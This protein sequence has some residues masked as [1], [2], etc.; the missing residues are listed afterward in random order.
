MDKKGK[1]L[2]LVQYFKN[3]FGG[4]SVDAAFGNL[5]HAGLFYFLQTPEAFKKL[6]LFLGAD[7]GDG[8][9]K[10]SGGLLFSF[11]LMIGDGKAVRLVPYSLEQE[12]AGAF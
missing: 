6:F 9:E 3:G 12:F 7:A 1:K 4:F 11:Y 10:R 2:F 5:F 8:V